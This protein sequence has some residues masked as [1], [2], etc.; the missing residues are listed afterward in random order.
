MQ[1]LSLLELNGLVAETL[2]HTLDREF[3]LTAE[4][5]EARVAAGGHC[6][7]ELIEKDADSGRLLAK[8][9][10]HIWRNTYALLAPY[11]E[12]KTG[13]RLA[14]GMKVLV[15]AA[16]EF[17]ELYGY[18]LNITDIDPAYTLGEQ[19]GRRKEILDR[20]E[21]DGVLTLNKELPLPRL[22]TRIA[23][24]SSSSAAG[25]GDFCDQLDR[26]GLRFTLRL[27]PATMQGE[28]VESSILNALDKIA[29]QTTE[30]DAVVIIRGGGAVSDLQGFETY[31]L[32]AA[33]AQFP[34]PIFTGIGH[35]RDDTVIDF[36]AHTRLKTPT[37]VAAFLIDHQRRELASLADWEERLTAAAQRRLHDER[38]RFERLAHRSQLAA[39]QQGS[40]ERERLLRL[41]ARLDG[42]LRSHIQNRRHRLDDLPLRLQ[43]AAERILQHEA[44][45]LDFW[46]KALTLAG[47]ERIL[48]LGFS[49]T[50]LNGRTLRNADEVKAGDRLVTTLEK[51]CVESIVQ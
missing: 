9:G 19:A 50:T 44:R 34:L 26:S 45:R 36:V 29:A 10:A 43:R 13:Q 46:Q 15:Q 3:W 6:Y 14:A 24:V 8:A 11:F 37:A 23:V 7:L 1:T 39:T 31:L 18:A 21:L 22:L 41:S 27:F 32:A 38:R 40:R 30:W 25:Y 33:V 20:L 51:G 48:R 28:L 16:V 17:H 49:I 12:R 5:S 2:R 4:V 35:E 47:P 42:A